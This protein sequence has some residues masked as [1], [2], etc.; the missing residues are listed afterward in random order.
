LKPG[1]IEDFERYDNYLRS[2][3]SQLVRQ[4]VEELLEAKYGTIE[5]S[6]REDLVEIVRNCQDEVLQQLRADHNKSIPPNPTCEGSY[7]MPVTDG[8]ALTNSNQEAGPFS[9]WLLPPMMSE[10]ISIPTLGDI[11]NTVMGLQ[12]EMGSDVGSYECGSIQNQAPDSFNEMF[13]SPEYFD[14]QL[15]ED[16]QSHSN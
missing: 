1:D 6:L 11:Q 2:N 9:A 7:L 12:P 15:P 4:R 14:F 10:E 3:L 5:E 13:I 16:D 8:T